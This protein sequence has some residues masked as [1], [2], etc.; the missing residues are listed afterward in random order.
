MIIG[1]IKSL[2]GYIHIPKHLKKILINNENEKILHITDTTRST[3]YGIKKL[4]KDI[5]PTYIIHTGDL[6]DDIKLELSPRSEFIYEKYVLEILKIMLDEN[7]KKI[8]IALGN[9]DRK[10][11]IDKHIN[12]NLKEEDKKRIVLIEDI[13]DLEI[14]NIKCTLSHY[15]HRIKEQNTDFNF[16]GHSLELKS[17][18]EDEKIYLNGLENINIIFLKERNIIKLQYPYGTDDN[19]TKKGKIGL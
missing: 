5:K 7:V 2:L 15:P 11:I 1:M 9:H 4:I 19:R 13:K 6:V 8:Y 3:F 16:F 17:K 18:I 12:N 10:N 14:Q